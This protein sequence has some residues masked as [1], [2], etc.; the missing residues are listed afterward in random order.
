MAN[1]YEVNRELLAC[2]DP[3]TGEIL[4]IE[5]FEN[6]S[7]S[8][9]QKIENIA[10]YIKNLQADALAFDTEEKTFAERKAKAKKKIEQLTRYLSDVLAGE[11]FSTKKCVVSFRRSQ[12]L[13]VTNAAQIPKEFIKYETTESVDKNAIKAAIKAGQAV[14]GCRIV[15]NFNISV[16]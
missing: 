13:E 15:E 10:L 5:K 8:K 7:I 6:L 11:N 2:I 1:L 16:K 4:D 14:D 3:D 12:K 9:S